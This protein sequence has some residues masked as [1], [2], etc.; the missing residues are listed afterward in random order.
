MI[1]VVEARHVRDYVIW[2]RFSD[3]RAG[4][5]DL[6]DELDGPV[7]EPLRQPKVFQSVYLHPEL[8]TIVWPTGADF[9]PEFLYERVRV[10]A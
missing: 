6:R 9:A 8:H 4:E 10:P 5:V 1:R 2:L 3:G 7:F